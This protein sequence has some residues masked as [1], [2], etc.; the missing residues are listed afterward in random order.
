MHG[1]ILCMEDDPAVAALIDR[2]LGD[3]GFDI[4]TVSTGEDGLFSIV[5]S[6]PDLILC[7]VSLPSMTRRVPCLPQ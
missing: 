3:R 1:T 4:T 7:D 6:T 5:T 2:E